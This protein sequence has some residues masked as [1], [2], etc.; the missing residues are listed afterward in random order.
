MKKIICLSILFLSM[1]MPVFA[2]TVYPPNARYVIVNP[3]GRLKA[4][5]TFLLDTK[6]GKT[7][8]YVED[9]LGFTSWEQ[10]EY[11][12]YKQDGTYGGK[13]FK[14]PILTSP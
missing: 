4:S 5:T 9:S 14:A 1:A 6:T 13:T 11:D 7:W 12:W 10:K 3:N 8:Q 2:D